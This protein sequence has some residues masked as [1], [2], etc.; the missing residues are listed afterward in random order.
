MKIPQNKL[1]KLIIKK[2]VINYFKLYLIIQI[3]LFHYLNHFS[4][5]LFNR[6]KDNSLFNK[7]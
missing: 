1:L 5:L 4:R 2:N 7:T 6:T 3:I